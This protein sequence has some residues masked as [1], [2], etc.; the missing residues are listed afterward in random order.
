MQQST[1]EKHS[2]RKGSNVNLLKLSVKRNES[3]IEV[4]LQSPIIETFF[5]QFG[6]MGEIGQWFEKEVYRL[7]PSMNN[8]SVLHQTLK[9]WGNSDLMPNGSPNLALLRMEGL[10]DGLT[11]NLNEYVYTRDDISAFI[12]TFKSQTIEL[13]NN[14][15]K[16]IESNIEIMIREDSNA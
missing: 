8:D 12:K 10:S 4:Y 15:I 1:I 11:L 2:I 13:Y 6:T 14:Y 5:K 16:S 7:P 3:G 9:N